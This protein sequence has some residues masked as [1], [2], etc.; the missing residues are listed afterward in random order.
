MCTASWSATYAVLFINCIFFKRLT[1]ISSVFVVSKAT[2]SLVRPMSL[3]TA[4]G[5]LLIPILLYGLLSSKSRWPT[6]QHTNKSTNC[7]DTWQLEIEIRLLWLELRA[8]KFRTILETIMTIPVTRKT[9]CVRWII[10][11]PYFIWQLSFVTS[12]LHSAA[13]RGDGVSG[14]RNTSWQ[15]VTTRTGRIKQ[16]P[17]EIRGF[18]SANIKAHY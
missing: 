8:P 10:R 18:N 1:D 13:R 6:R 2:S 4:T 14:V 9:F 17:Y 16:W 7:F 11:Y 15:T 5:V 12:R 3:L